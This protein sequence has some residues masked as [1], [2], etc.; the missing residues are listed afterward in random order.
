MPTKKPPRVTGVFKDTPG[1]SGFDLDGLPP[2][3]PNLSTSQ[4]NQI[5]ETGFAGLDLPMEYQPSSE[6]VRIQELEAQLA[7]LAA[8]GSNLA[9]QDGTIS[10]HG[11]SLSPVGLL[12][13]ESFDRDQWQQIGDLLW[14]LEGSI[15]WLLGDWLVYGEDLQYGDVKKIADTLEKDYKTLR[16]Y[17]TV[18]RRVEL[19]RR[20]DNL[21]WGHHAEITKYDADLQEQ[22]LAYAEQSR[23]SRA[24]FRKFLREQVDGIT[25]PPALTA[26][27]ND[28]PMILF[29]EAM[30][31]SKKDI[32][33]VSIRDLKA[34][35]EDLNSVIQI[36]T[37]ERERMIAEVDKRGKKNA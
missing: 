36:A 11:F 28:D 10:I 2:V 30:A 8:V 32:T 19:S 34:A 31:I 1:V 3:S 33:Q 4:V 21:S 18:S 13:P 25:A 23:M 37:Q 24:D 22:C 9:V 16:N 6:E 14:R 29:R 12:A 15:Q 20:R 17:M 26:S 27:N 5:Y 35:V 7:N